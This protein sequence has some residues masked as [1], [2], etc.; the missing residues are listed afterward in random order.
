MSFGQYLLASTYL[1]CEHGAIK[2]WNTSSSLG[3]TG[4]VRWAEKT[5]ITVYRTNSPARL[6]QWPFCATTCWEEQIHK[7]RLLKIAPV[8]SQECLSFPCAESLASLCFFWFWKWLSSQ[9]FSFSAG[10]STQNNH[11]TWCFSKTN[12]SYITQCC[13]NQWNH[14]P[15]DR[16]IFLWIKRSLHSSDWN[17]M[18]PKPCSLVSKLY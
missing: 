14:M 7:K 8:V 16:E 9:L 13:T 10:H 1:P 2:I 11:T 18:D 5:T 15:Q 12:L 3:T 4:L 6:P 17:H